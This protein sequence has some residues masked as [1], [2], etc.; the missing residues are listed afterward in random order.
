MHM[1]PTILYNTKQKMFKKSPWIDL[2]YF[3]RSEFFNES[4]ASDLLMLWI[5]QR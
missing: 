1:P 3:S 4:I 2:K 5:I